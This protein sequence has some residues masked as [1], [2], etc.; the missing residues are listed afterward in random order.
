MSSLEFD[1]DF[2]GRLRDLEREWRGASEVSLVARAVYESIATR[3]E[4]DLV[5]LAG[6]REALERSEAAKSRIMTKIE[7]LEHRVLRLL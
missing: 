1:F 3:S 4:A 5:A 2:D 6:A 7:R